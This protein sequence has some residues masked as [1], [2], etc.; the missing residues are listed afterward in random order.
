MVAARTKALVGTSI[1]A[2]FGLVAVALLVL[3]RMSFAVPIAMMLFAVSIAIKYI[4]TMSLMNGLVRKFIKNTRGQLISCMCILVLLPVLLAVLTLPVKTGQ[5]KD[6]AEEVLQTT[7]TTEEF[8]VHGALST[9]ATG[10]DYTPVEPRRTLSESMF[11]LNVC[12][13]TILV[14]IF[15]R[16]AIMTFRTKKQGRKTR[17]ETML[18]WRCLNIVPWV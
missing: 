4:V 12:T 1:V 7:P 13:S 6:S 15:V 17:A 2:I 10:E 18:F 9:V 14:L 11:V 8:V 5:T 16:I 3:T